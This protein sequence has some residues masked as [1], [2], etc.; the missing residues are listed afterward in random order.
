MTTSSIVW[1]HA[2]A[3]AMRPGSALP[4]LPLPLLPLDKATLPVRLRHYWS[5]WLSRQSPAVAVAPPVI[6]ALLDE[7]GTSGWRIRRNA[8]RAIVHLC[9]AAQPTAV[10][11]FGSGVSTVI[12]A[13]LARAHGWPM[14]IVS[15]EESPVYAER[16]RE[17][18]RRYG[19]ADRVTVI[20]APVEEQTLDGWRGFTY[21]TDDQA[22]VAA[23]RGL[24]PD[25]LFFDGPA[26][27]L[28]SRRDC[29]Y[30]NLLVAQRY[31]ANGA[32]FVADD[33]FRRRDR[34]ILAR[35]HAIDGVH[36][37][38]LFPLGRGLGLGMLHPSPGATVAP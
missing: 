1:P 27:W 19:V 10:L 30:G 22:V 20:V 2:S 14:P 25:F 23:L 26:S 7:L 29:R 38:G 13:A 35:W 21:R 5:A 9:D 16:T 3:A 31:A 32:L 34:A 28:R 4:G 15:I 24:R 18:L 6:E 33:A 11:E 37:F 12:F 36:V 17:L 8:A